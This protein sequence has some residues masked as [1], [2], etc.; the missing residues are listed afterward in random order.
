MDVLLPS[1]E[2]EFT[3]K[4]KEVH[5]LRSS[6]HIARG[7]IL[8]LNIFDGEVSVLVS[9]NEHGKLRKKA[10]S[11]LLIA[12]INALWHC[13]QTV[14][15]DEEEENKC[16]INPPDRCLPLPALKCANMY[17]L[18]TSQ[19]RKLKWMLT[20]VNNTLYVV[21]RIIKSREAQLAP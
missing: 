19:Q 5:I 7:T 13:D 9:F 18:T 1:I 20:Q 4:N 10:V 14:S 2:L 8:K 15:S 17:V 3:W 11:P 12:N 16:F 6:G 21:D